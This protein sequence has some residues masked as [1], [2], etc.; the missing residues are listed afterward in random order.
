MPR[1]GVC[2]RV[3]VTAYCDA[4]FNSAHG[5]AWAIW[6]ASAQ[7]RIIK[8]G[9]CPDYVRDANAAELAALYAAVYSACCGW[10]GKVRGITLRSDSQSALHHA[11]PTVRLA[12]NPGV[13]RLQDLLRT[14]LIKHSVTVELQWVRGHQKPTSGTQAY[15]NGACDKLAKKARKLRA[16]E[17]KAPR[18]EELG[19]DTS[20]R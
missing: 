8:R 18:D 5:G 7:G 10:P 1:T 19:R 4:S 15:L 3:W 9:A 17:G 13:R 2:S 14:C 16:A 12:R 6:L 20:R 11:S